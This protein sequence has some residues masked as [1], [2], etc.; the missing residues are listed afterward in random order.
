MSLLESPPDAV[1]R[2]DG[3]PY[4]YFAGTS[5]L[6]LQG[7]PEV[8]RAACEAAERF[9]LGSANSRTAF[10]TTPPLLQMEQAAAATF[11]AEAAFCFASGWMGGHILIGSLDADRVVALVDE[12]SHFSLFEAAR[13][14]GRP[15]VVFRHADPDDLRAK[16]QKHLGVG[17]R[18]LVLSDGVFAATGDLAPVDRYLEVLRE[19]PDSSLLL[20]DAHGLGVL[21]PRGRGTFEHFGI[22]ADEVNTARAPLPCPA[23]WCCG[24]LSK[25][26]GGYGGVILS[27]ARFIE[28]LQ[29]DS[30]YMAGVSPPPAPV[31]AATARALELIASEPE[32]RERLSANARRLKDGLRA[33]G[34]SVSESPTPIARLV[35]GTAER[36]R[37]IQRELM[38]RGI[39]VAYMSN[40]AGLDPEGALRLAVF[41]THTDAMIDRLFEELRQVAT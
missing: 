30:P 40:Y 1:V 34:F 6:G 21:G 8:I 29:A 31:A 35:I 37:R 10:G 22:A 41:A 36:M 3:R 26:V 16:I 25:A 13:T 33:M 12:H 18:P 19:Y 38:N 9:G 11:G 24:T 7:R 4:L 15:P 2:I 39:A 27:D 14:I 17:Q 20:D 32:L 28:Q 5:Y 23:L